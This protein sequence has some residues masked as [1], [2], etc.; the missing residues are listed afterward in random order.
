M[1]GA[2]CARRGNVNGPG[3]LIPTVE[4]V[5]GARLR[6]IHKKEVRPPRSGLRRFAIS[7]LISP[8]LAQR[9]CDLGIPLAEVLAIGQIELRVELLAEARGQ[10]F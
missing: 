3:Y 2:C 1:R 7:R 10:D 5:P 6:R 9:R 8:Q 4:A